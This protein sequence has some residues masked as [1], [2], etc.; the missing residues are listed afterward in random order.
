M[1]GTAG[2]A[3]WRRKRFA[4]PIALWLAVAYPLSLG[5]VRYAEAR[6][7]ISTTALDRYRK[8]YHLA[9]A[10]A[11]LVDRYCLWWCDLGIRHANAERERH[12]RETIA[13]DR[14]IDRTHWTPSEGRASNSADRRDGP[15]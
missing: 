13:P 12:W 1:D 6:G 7:W 9:Y 10:A 15:T 4:V 11:D 3:W 2:R 14:S 8:P 5:P